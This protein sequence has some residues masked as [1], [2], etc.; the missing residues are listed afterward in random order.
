[1]AERS[2]KRK[3]EDNDNGITHGSGI[4]RQ[5][6]ID[7]DFERGVQAERG[8]GALKTSTEKKHD[9]RLIVVLENANL[10][11]VK[12]GKHV[13]LLNSDKH[14]NILKKHNRDL[15]SARPDITHQTLLCLMD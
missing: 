13:E 14:K 10:E 3:L 11:L 12:N 15:G 4:H 8:L 6:D 7:E 9:K 2:K 1:M 5:L